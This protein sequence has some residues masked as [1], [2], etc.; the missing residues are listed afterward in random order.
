M[1]GY[2]RADDGFHTGHYVHEVAD[3]VGDIID[4][5]LSRAAGDASKAAE[6]LEARAR[7]DS[8]LYRTL[9]E[10]SLPAMCRET[11]NAW[12]R[13][14]R[15]KIFRG[16]GHP[17]AATHVENAPA[18]FS[19]DGRSSSAHHTASAVAPSHQMGD[20]LLSA[21]RYA[22]LMELPLPVNQKPLRF[23]TVEDVRN[24][25]NYYDKR[26][27]TF[28]RRSDFFKRV[29]KRMEIGKPVGECMDENELRE[30]W[31]AQ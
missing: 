1:D 29:L 27:K 3:E 6:L 11:V 22:S 7:S 30:I 15:S 17:V 18:L 23:A 24:A 16:G 5:C 9:T 31:N 8:D 20:R 13:S 21:M 10:R 25:T 28:R 12:F 2:T 4:E 14:R 26:A 19:S